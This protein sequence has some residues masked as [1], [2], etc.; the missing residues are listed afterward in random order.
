MK[1]K[2]EKLV[3][4]GSVLCTLSLR[5]STIY[6]ESTSIIPIYFGYLSQIHC[7]GKLYV[8]AVG[9]LRLVNRE[10]FPKELG[11]GVLIQPLGESGRTD[12][13]LKTS[14]G[15][16]HRILEIRKAEGLLS[17]DRLEVW[18]DSNK[19]KDFLDSPDSL[20]SKGRR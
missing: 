8:S 7:S 14:L 16:F 15:D 12:L 5:S 1:S 9:N 18:F 17:P 6:A 3:F 20:A 4:A 19:A 13:L 11:C 10:A 2:I